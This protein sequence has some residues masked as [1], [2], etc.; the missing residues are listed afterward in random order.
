MA[1][2]VQKYGGGSLADFHK[3]GKITRL[4]ANTKG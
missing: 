3:L 4:I 1:C 2:I